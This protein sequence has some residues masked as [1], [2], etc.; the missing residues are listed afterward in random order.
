MHQNQRFRGVGVALVTPFRQGAIDWDGLERIIEHV[1]DGNV[2]YLVVL[3]TTGEAA[4]LS[5]TEHRQVLDFA[6]RCNRGRKP[7]IAGVFGSNNTPVL[8]DKIKHFNFDGIDGLLSSNPAYVKPSQEGHYQHYMALAEVSP[9]PI[10][11]YNVPGRSAVNM[12]AETTLR[13]ARAGGSQFIGVK[14]ASDDLMQIMK[15]IQGRPEGFLVLSGD[16]YIVL[17]VVAAGGDGVVSVIANNMPHMF[18]EMVHAALRDDLY[19]ARTLNLRMLDMYKLL[20]IEGNPVG[21]KA[22]LELQGM[23]SREVRLPLTP[24]TE[25]GVALLKAEM[26]SL[27]VDG[28]R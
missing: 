19:M 5:D 16:D 4:S 14:D 25:A 11:L 15:I 22:L 9:R 8:V 12:T 1:I 2:D 24:M 17:P 21:T 26:S 27:M 18:S 20:F 10:M 3:G 7:L 28:R 6:I 13:L 23:C